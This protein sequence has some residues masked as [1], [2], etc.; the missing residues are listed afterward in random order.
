MPISTSHPG[1][2]RVDTLT[3]QLFVDRYPK[4]INTQF[5]K[6]PNDKKEYNK[7]IKNLTSMC[8]R[9]AKIFEKSLK[10]IMAEGIKE[11]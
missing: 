1:L 11:D 9:D 6:I 4:F 3:I 7:A 2:S 10:E 8:Y 5:Y